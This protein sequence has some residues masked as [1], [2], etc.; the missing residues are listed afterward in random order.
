[1]RGGGHGRGRGRYRGNQGYQSGKRNGHQ[2][3]FGN[4]NLVDGHGNAETLSTNS[5][6]PAYNAIF[7]GL[8]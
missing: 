7:G 6:F 4:V 2:G 5:D 1:M 8:A 3:G